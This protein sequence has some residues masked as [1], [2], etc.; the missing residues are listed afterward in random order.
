VSVNGK[1]LI[2]QL[3]FILLFS[4]LALIAQ[5]INFSRLVGSSNQYFTFF[6]FMGPL[7]ASFLGLPAGMAAILLTQLA[8]YALLGKAID[9]VGAWRLL[10]M[11]FAAYYFGYGNRLVRAA[12]PLL[13]MAAFI[14][15]PVGGQ[16]WFYSLYWLIP[17][18]ALKFEH[19]LLARSLGATFTAHA[20]GG[21][22]WV[23]TVPM[24]AEAW[25]A[26]IPIVAYE[27]GL[28]ALGIAASHIAFNTVLSAF[29][30]LLP[31]RVLNIERRYVLLRA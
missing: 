19:N 13:C 26:L 15:H 22:F 14:S 5:N 27:R 16:V 25:I 17:I 2:T 12:I 21:A 18:L 30:S 29:E 11:L 23:W 6:Q 28:F 9:F 3:F 20:V 1:R 8:N 31:H 4:A 10:P 24:P 7:P